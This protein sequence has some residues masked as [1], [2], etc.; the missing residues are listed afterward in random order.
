MSNGE[1]IGTP[2]DD[3]RAAAVDPL[4]ARVWDEVYNPE[5]SPAAGEGGEA[6]ASAAGGS[7]APA[8]ALEGARAAAAAA[9]AQAP[10]AAANGS[11]AGVS[12]DQT[13]TGS[14]A[15]GSAGA[16]GAGIPNPAPGAE[17]PAATTGRTH[18]SVVPLLTD[19]A[20]KI[21]E[22]LEHSF[23][24]S[25]EQSVRERIDPKYYE[26]TELHPLQLVGKP[27]PSVN[28]DDKPF[29]PRDTQDARDWIDATKMLIEAEVKD[30]TAAK[31]KEAQPLRSIIQDSVM[32]LTNNKDLIPGTVE[33][34]PELNRKFTAMAQ[35]FEM[36]GAKG[37]LLGYQGNMQPL[38]NELRTDLATQRGTTA[39]AQSAQAQAAA[40]DRNALGQFDA[41]QAG[42]T[43]KS[44]LAGEGGDDYDTFWRAAL[45]GVNP[46]LVI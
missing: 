30:I 17:A 2:S 43:S 8:T 38:I 13:D 6:S 19:A 24:A 37:E 18:E 16:A 44:D 22:R 21:N 25:A 14:G 10:G 11:A 40:Q 39:G 27:L 26:Y 23:R 42:L 5:E 28:G 29:V 1:P 46:G 36:R 20:Q 35:P 3:I 15:S 34:D 31:E 32:M 41:P 7:E 4:F 33:Y 45:P 9:S 12:V